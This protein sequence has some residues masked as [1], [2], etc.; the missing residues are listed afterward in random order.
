LTAPKLSKAIVFTFVLSFS[1]VCSSQD[2]SAPLDPAAVN[3]IPI[4]NLT[5]PD[6][7]TFSSGQPTQEE[8]KALAQAGIKHI[9]NLRTAEE[10]DWNEGDLV[11]SL[12]MQY[13]SV[14]V[15]G[16][17]GVTIENATTLVD[18]LKEIDGEPALLHC[19]SG[20]RVGAL[21]ALREGALNGES[22]DDS[23]ATG[24]LWGLTGLEPVVRERLPTPQ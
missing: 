18:I 6:Q 16:A 4:K 10:Q 3:Q 11:Q 19:G 9:I 23:V 20:N 8:I 22:I 2:D 15:A 17:A 13:H 12:G 14:P 5:N 1:A 24:K 21:I 7:A